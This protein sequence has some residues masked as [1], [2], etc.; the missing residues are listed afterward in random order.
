MLQPLNLENS[1][2][3]RD[4]VNSAKKS[5]FYVLRIR[6]LNN[7]KIGLDVNE[8]KE[9]EIAVQQLKEIIEQQALL[10]PTC[11]TNYQD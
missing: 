3:T 11:Q 4:Q 10:H 5:H 9:K 8:E 1:K 2:L 6:P 7:R